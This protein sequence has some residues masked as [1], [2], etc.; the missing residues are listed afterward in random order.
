MR[1][2]DIK[3]L[4]KAIEFYTR[5]GVKFIELD[6]T[7]DP[8]YSHVTKPFDRADFFVKDKTLVA[9]GEQSFIEKM[10]KGE[11]DENVVYMGIT[12]CFRDEDYEDD[13]HKYYFLKL[14]LFTISDD[15]KKYKQLIELAY[16][17]FTSEL[18]LTVN[19]CKTG[20]HSMDIMSENNIELGSYLHYSKNIDG[21]DYKWSCGTGVAM[22][23]IYN[24][25]MDGQAF[26]CNN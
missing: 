9:S 1:I 26:T 3:M 10:C 14:E 21:V 25:F 2:E 18:S 23:R 13:L 15:S 12:P 19:S 5:H 16:R 24:A 20:K 4:S 7:V 17:F 22:P 8:L 6:W 11:L